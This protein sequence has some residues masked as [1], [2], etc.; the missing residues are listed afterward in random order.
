MEVMVLNA[1]CNNILVISL[2]SVLL[3]EETGILGENHQPAA[4]HF[5]TLQIWIKCT[6]PSTDIN[7]TMLVVIGTDYTGSFKHCS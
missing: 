2:R 5:I 4:S 3:V 1:T 7:L 6:L